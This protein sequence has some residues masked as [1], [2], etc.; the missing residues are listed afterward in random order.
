[1]AE[2]LANAAVVEFAAASA[3]ESCCG[4][5]NYELDAKESKTEWGAG[6]AAV[7]LVLTLSQDLLSE[8]TWFALA[9]PPK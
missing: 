3:D 5:G 8:A 6:S 4:R 1:M 7:E 9:L 2:G